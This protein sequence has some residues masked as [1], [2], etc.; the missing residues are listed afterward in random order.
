MLNEVVLMGRLTATPV[1]NQTKGGVLVTSFA[2]AIDRRY[3]RQGEEKKTDFINCVAWQKTA[4]FIS[5]Y[6]KKGEMI[7]ITG[8]IQTRPYEDRNGNNRTATEVIINN[9]SFC[10]NKNDNVNAP[11]APATGNLNN[12]DDDLPF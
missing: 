3:Q 12:Y 10:G 8:E 9:V 2:I 11:E 5:K 1:L 6:F 7:A 4:E